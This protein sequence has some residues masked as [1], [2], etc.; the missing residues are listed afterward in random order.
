MG[1]VL[2]RISTGLNSL[3]LDFLLKIDIKLLCIVKTAAKLAVHTD[4]PLGPITIC[5]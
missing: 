5:Y 2:E 3:N 4:Y 1:V